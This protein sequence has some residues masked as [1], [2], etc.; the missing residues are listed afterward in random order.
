[1]PFKLALLRAGRSTTACLT[2]RK[3][4]D[5][6]WKSTLETLA[7]WRANGTVAGI[8][9]GDEQCYHGVSLQNLTYVTQLIRKDWPEAVLYINEAQDL[10]MCNFNRLNETFFGD[11]DCWPE[12]LDWLGFDICVQPPVSS[13]L[14]V[15]PGCTNY[16]IRARIRW[17]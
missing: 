14:T 7:P 4:I 16:M 5:D 13:W 1:M 2:I 9:L 6:V 15:A 12:E 11:G 17:F 8:F 10:L 3:D